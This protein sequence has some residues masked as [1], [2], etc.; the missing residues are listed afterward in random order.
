MIIN[1]KRHLGLLVVREKKTKDYI[2]YYDNDYHFNR[3]Y[4]GNVQGIYDTCYS[5]L[6]EGQRLPNSHG[7]ACFDYIHHEC[8]KPISYKKLPEDVQK[9]LINYINM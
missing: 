5:T 3:D 8:T 9:H 6:Q 4:A 7:Q 2:F 1:K